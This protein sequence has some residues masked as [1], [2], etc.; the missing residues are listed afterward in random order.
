[1]QVAYVNTTVKGYVDLEELIKDQDPTFAW[2]SDKQYILQNRGHGNIVLNEA[3]DKPA[4]LGSG[5][6]L[7][8][9]KSAVFKPSTGTVWVYAPNN[10]FYINVSEG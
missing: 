3:D 2:D 9:Q 4:E 6:L 10:T 5:L 8:P 1:M 7:A